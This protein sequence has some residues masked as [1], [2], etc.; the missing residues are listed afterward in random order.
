MDSQHNVKNIQTDFPFFF[1]LSQAFVGQ[2]KRFE[3]ALQQLRGVNLDISHEANQ[4][5]VI[6]S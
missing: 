6:F 2:E 5:R 3:S 4:I 1:F